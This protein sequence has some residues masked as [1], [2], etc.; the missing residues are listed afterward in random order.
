MIGSVRVPVVTPSML[1]RP[2]LAWLS[3]ADAGGTEY[4]LANAVRRP[5]AVRAFSLACRSSSAQQAGLVANCAKDP[6]ALA[7]V[8]LLQFDQSVKHLSCPTG[9]AEAPTKT[10]PAD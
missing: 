5:D 2:H 10:N 7:Q 3:P 1:L 4:I 9:G 6:A 8:L